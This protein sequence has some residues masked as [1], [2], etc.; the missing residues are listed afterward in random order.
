MN[1]PP[2]RL[3]LPELVQQNAEGG[4]FSGFGVFYKNFPVVV[5]LNY[6]LYQGKAQAPTPFFG[7]K[8]GVKYPV[9]VLFL[10]SF[11]GIGNID[12]HL[13]VSGR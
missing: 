9:H 3:L 12:G 5:I 6:A 2:A 8:A 1:K 10:H 4:S 7:G 13:M 11:P